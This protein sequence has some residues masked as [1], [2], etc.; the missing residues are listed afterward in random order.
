MFMMSSFFLQLAPRARSR[1]DPCQPGRARLWQRVRNGLCARRSVIGTMNALHWPF[2]QQ[3]QDDGRLR[4]RDMMRA[5]GAFLPHP[6]TRL[7][8]QDVVA[9][10]QRCLACRD[11]PLC[12]RHLAAGT[13]QGYEL[14]CPNSGYI[15]RL[16]HGALKC[17]R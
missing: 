14:F 11:T 6:L 3:R 17:R 8:A 13:T 10:T 7:A 1:L 15:E 5:R 12:D 4:L 9:A 16:R 2:W